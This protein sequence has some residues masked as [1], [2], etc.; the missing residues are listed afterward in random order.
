MKTEIQEKFD[1]FQRKEKAIRGISILLA[2]IPFILGTAWFYYSYERVQKLNKQYTKK[3]NQYIDINKKVK[4]EEVKYNDLQDKKQKLEL[5]LIKSYG[6][7]SDSTINVTE[8]EVAIMKS[9]KANDAIKTLATNYTPNPKILIRYYYK[10]IDDEK[11]VLSLKSLGY[12]FDQKN[13][14]EPTKNQKT[15]SIWIGDKVT[16]KDCKIVALTLMRAGI[17]IKAIRTFRNSKTNPSYKENI[18]EIGGDMNLE[19][20]SILPLTLEQV[21]NATSFLRW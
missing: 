4:A 3:N 14:S 12:Y 10:T 19:N 13:S 9:V 20:Q 6:F 15:N 2:I 5:E 7:S 8:K 11:I 17:Q 18:I 21:E 16:V 1:N